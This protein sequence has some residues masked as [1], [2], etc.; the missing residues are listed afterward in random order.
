[1]IT[2]MSV[3]PGGLV[4]SLAF[5]IRVLSCCASTG[6]FLRVHKI[7]HTALYYAM[8]TIALINAEDAYYQWPFWWS[9][10][11]RCA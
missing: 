2:A 3:Q 4:K 10:I 8:S 7:N 9:E 6:L 1:M 11:Y 5:A